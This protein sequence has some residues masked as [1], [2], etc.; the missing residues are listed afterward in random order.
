MKN[1]LA[2]SHSKEM[3]EEIDFF[4]GKNIQKFV[5]LQMVDNKNTKIISF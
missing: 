5:G 2:L 1:K 4:G 3:D